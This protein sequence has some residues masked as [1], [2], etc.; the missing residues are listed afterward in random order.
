MDCPRCGEHEQV[1]F[2]AEP[3]PGGFRIFDRCMKCNATFNNGW[4]A[5]DDEKAPFESGGKDNDMSELR[6]RQ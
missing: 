3:Q 6:G 2:Y 1:Y 4:Y 5:F